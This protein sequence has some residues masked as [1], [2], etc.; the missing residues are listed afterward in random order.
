MQI[1]AVSLY[2]KNLSSDKEYHVQ[3]TQV[4][5]GYCVTAQ[6]GARGGT[7]SHARRAG[8]PME[9]EIAEKEYDKLV[10][11]KTKK[12]YSTG[13]AGMAFVGGD[14][15]ERYTGVTPQLLNPIYAGDELKY[16]RDPNWGIEEKFDG[17]RRLIQTTSTEVLGIKRNGLVAGLPQSVLDA[18]KVLQ[19]DPTFGLAIL[20]GEL[21]G[22]VFALFDVLEIGGKDIRTWPLHK[23]IEVRDRLKLQLEEAGTPGMFGAHTVTSEPEK[24]VFYSALVEIKAEGAVFKELDTEYVPGRPS[25]GGTQLKLKFTHRATLVV[26]KLHVSKR[27][28]RVVGFGASGERIAL[29]NC[30]I[31][32]NQNMPKADDLVEIEYLYAFKGGS[33]FQPQFKGLRDDIER[34]DCTLKQL[35]YK[36]DGVDAEDVAEENDEV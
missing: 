11:S 22:D 25:K 31:P 23:R 26:D 30:T 14:L 32:P 19:A 2:L 9:Y 7:L 15:E 33:L 1:K 34:A 6:N 4:S 36:A 29:G 27:S 13:E 28:V 17:H 20:D 18:V 35:H 16:F 8:V 21:M 5:D 3:L 24:R 10:K 12:G